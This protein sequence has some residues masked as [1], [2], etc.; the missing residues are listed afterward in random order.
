[1]SFRLTFDQP[2]I[3]I[4]VA[5]RHMRRVNPFQSDRAKRFAALEAENARLRSIAADLTA[6]ILPLQAA[7]GGTP[8]ERRADRAAASRTPLA[9]CKTYG[10]SAANGVKTAANRFA[11]QPWECAQ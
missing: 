5:G 10:R 9:S 11:D 6:D 1:V 8:G 2:G 3:V 4:A 7:L